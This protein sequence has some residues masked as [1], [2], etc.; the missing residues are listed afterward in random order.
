[1]ALSLAPAGS[2]RQAWLAGWNGRHW[3]FEGTARAMEDAVPALAVVLADM[4]IGLT[5]V[6]PVPASEDVCVALTLD[7][8]EPAEESVEVTGIDKL[9]PLDLCARDT[10]SASDAG[11]PLRWDESMVD[12]EAVLGDVTRDSGADDALKSE[13]RVAR[14]FG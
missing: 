5:E 10:A 3:C 4:G 9:L 1:M 8:I 7:A 11:E 12:V 14:S 13:V 2:V 6:V